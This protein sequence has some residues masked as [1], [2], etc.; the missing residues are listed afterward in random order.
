MWDEARR[1]FPIGSRVR[2][3]VIDHR[4]FGIFVDRG[5]SE[6]LG[7][8][9]VTDFRDE[10]RMTPDQYPPIG[11]TI[12]EIVLG[13]TSEQRKQV[14]LEVKPGLLTRPLSSRHGGLG[15]P[16]R[17]PIESQVAR[18]G[19]S[20]LPRDGEMTRQERSVSW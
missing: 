5:V 2:G 11:A 19:Q 1:R 8:V 17:H 18:A 16:R 12:E 4:P 15:P 20:A 10:G 14:W 9:Q 6:I 7:L 13:H 3:T